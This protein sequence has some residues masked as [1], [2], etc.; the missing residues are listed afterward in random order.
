MAVYY[1]FDLK[2]YIKSKRDSLSAS[3]LTTY[4]SILKSLYKK[5][6]G[7]GDIDPKKFDDDEAILASLKDI[8]PNRR[9]TILSALVIATNNSKYRDLMLS[10]VREYNQE[11]KKQEK[12]PAQEENWATEEDILKLWN[13]S[14]KEATALYKKENLTMNDLQQI[15]SFIILSLLGGMFIP[16]R[17][18][19]D[20]TDF[21]IKSIDKNAD[22]F[23][24][25]ATL[26]FNSYKTSKTYGRQEVAVPKPLMAILK[27]WIKVNPTD[28]LL[29]DTNSNPL[30]SV[31]LNQR[32]NR[33]FDGRKIA[34]NALRHSYLTTKYKK[35]SEESKALT[36]DMTDMGSSASMADTYIK[37]N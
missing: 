33:I 20:M 1:M 2:G 4:G 34:I 19:K 22:N 10:D 24:E 15:Q 29:F 25:K 21:K 30:T 36:N 35:H 5:C 32:I 16:P 3:S 26:V 14:K 37:L 9:K 11:I 8:P 12:S 27:K 13:E 23:I 18:A 6:F 28:Y 17:R 31:K 7:D